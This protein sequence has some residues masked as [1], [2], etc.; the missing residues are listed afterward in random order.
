[1]IFNTGVIRK[2]P[3]HVY[4]N[5]QG[6]ALRSVSKTLAL[7]QEPFDSKTV[8]RRIATSELKQKG[9]S[10]HRQIDALMDSIQTGWK[11]YGKERAD[12]GTGFHQAC[13]D[14]IKTGKCDPQ[15]K[16]LVEK[17]YMI[18]FTD[19]YRSYAEVIVSDKETIAGTGDA[20]CLHSSKQQDLIHIRD[21]K[22]N[23]K[24]PVNDVNPKASNKWFLSPFDHMLDNKYNYYAM[25]QSIYAYLL[26][27][28]GFRVASIALIWVHVESGEHR[29]IDIPFMREEAKMLVQYAKTIH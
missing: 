16:E 13:E 23:L 10:D 17:I 26:T 27:L 25:Q 11:D 19:F 15:H 28:M 3:E 6:L 8:S 24:M 20:F 9:I 14:F 12:A 21:F 7:I 22:T 4:Y 1:M 29:R 18:Y 5:A 2:D